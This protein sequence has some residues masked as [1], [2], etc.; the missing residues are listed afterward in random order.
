MS[1]TAIITSKYRLA[2]LALAATA[3][4]GL[5]FS[6]AEAKMPNIKRTS[7]AVI[8]FDLAPPVE[9]VGSTADGTAEIVISE[10]KKSS[11]SD[12]EVNVTGLLEGTYTV[13]ATLEQLDPAVPAETLPLGT[14]TVGPAV[15]PPADGEAE[16]DESE[17]ELDLEGIDLDPRSITSITISKAIDATTSDVVLVGTASTETSALKFFAKVRV[18]APPASALTTTPDPTEEPGKGKGKGG[19]SKTKKVHGHALAMSTIVEGVEKKRFFLFV[20]HGAPANAVLNLVIDGVTIPDFTVTATK[21]GKVMFKSLSTDIDLEA[22]DL[23]TLTT[24]T[25]EGAVPVMQADF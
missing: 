2:A 10:G 20:A 17:F 18:T 11:S 8:S 9:D 5:S 13:V 19:P 23:L 1:R 16:V 22:I 15:P 12:L 24:E 14:F 4:T 21:S 6:S 25:A 3:F 7:E